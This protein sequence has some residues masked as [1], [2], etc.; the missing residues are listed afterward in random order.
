MG[1]KEWELDLNVH[2]SLKLGMILRKTH[3]L[4]VENTPNTNPGS[5]HLKGPFLQSSTLEIEFSLELWTETSRWG[6]KTLFKKIPK[7]IR[8]FSLPNFCV[9]AYITYHF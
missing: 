8:D 9:L 4:R 2:I 7:L 5:S 1:I 3:E 6:I